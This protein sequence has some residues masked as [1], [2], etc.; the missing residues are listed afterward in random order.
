MKYLRCFFVVF[1]AVSAMAV[2]SSCKK[3]KDEITITGRVFDQGFGNYLEGATVKLS[4]NGIQNGIYT[5]DYVQ[6]ESVTTDASGNFKF[7]R[8]KDRTD[9]F[10]IT[11]V[12]S[13]YFSEEHIF[14]SNVFNSSNE[15]NQEISVKPAGLVQVH[16]YNAYPSDENDKVVFYF[17]NSNLSCFDCCTNI[18]STGNGPAFDTTF[19][20]KFLGNKNIC[21]L[22]SVTKD[23]H[24]NVY[25]DSLF[26]PA[27][28][29]TT[30]HIAY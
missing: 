1:A 30:Y 4:G 23:Q 8:K 28:Q 12:K 18:P 22:R 29:T 26:C 11:V 27:F 13:D 5:P 14:S 7:T 21:F 6:L 25:L 20:C 15:Y 24:T 9:S 10:R 19:T 16:L 17:S 2:L 3:N